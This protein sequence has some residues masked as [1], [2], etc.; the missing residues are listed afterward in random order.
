MKKPLGVL[1][2]LGDTVLEYY[3]NSPMEGAKKL[4]ENSKNPYKVKAEEIQELAEKL[5]KETF[6]KRDM[7]DME[8]NFQSFQRLL[9]EN[10][11]IEFKVN[12]LEIEKLFCKHAFKSKPSEG[13]QAL[14]NILD[15]KKIKYAALSNS[16]FTSKTLRYEL[17]ESGLN[18]NFQFI[19]SSNEYCLR[20]PNKL[21]FDLEAK[22][23]KVNSS[24]IWFIGDSYKY[25]MLGAKSAGML[26]IFYNRKNSPMTND[27]ELLEVKSMYEIEKLIKEI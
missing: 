24:D 9:Y 22:K 2:D 16:S 5:T 25:D 11:N 8:V 7:V 18:T 10:F 23:L 14:F 15:E 6:S 1:F 4:L 3:Y 17:K 12:M 20:K 13:V 26:P 27:I 21:L 19:M